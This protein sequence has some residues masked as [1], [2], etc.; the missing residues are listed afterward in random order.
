MA[1]FVHLAAMQD[2]ASIRRNGLK[3]RRFGRGTEPSRG[4][5]AMP[6]T[7]D[8]QISHQWL[9]EMRRWRAGLIHGVY[10]RVPDDEAVYIGVYNARHERM[11][12]A[13]ALAC[14]LKTPQAGLQVIVPRAVSTREIFRIKALP[15]IVGWRVWPQ[16]KGQVPT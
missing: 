16:A 7:P 1:T 6:V 5:F 8:F 10:F 13:E 4:V 9:R 11:S 12:A 3:A 15:Q 14:L 2:V